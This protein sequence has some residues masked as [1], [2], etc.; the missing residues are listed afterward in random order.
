LD[1]SAWIVAHDKVRSLLAK[2]LPGVPVFARELRYSQLISGSPPYDK[3]SGNE[4]KALADEAFQLIL[5]LKPVLFAAAID[6]VAH[7]AEWGYNAIAPNVWALQLIAP[8]FRK[9]L[10]RIDAR[11]IFVMDAEERRKDAKLKELIQNARQQG[12]VLTSSYNPLLTNTNL[13]RLI[14]TVIFVNSDESPGIQL[15]D[16]AGHAVWRH[17]ERNQSDRF[18]QIRPLFDRLGGVEYGLK[19]WQP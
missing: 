13:P 12:I 10:V 5:E 4:R 19:I 3:L 17:F 2:Y 11:G 7:K 9:Y 15:A 8:R 6:K 1:E 16:F 14:E 18:N